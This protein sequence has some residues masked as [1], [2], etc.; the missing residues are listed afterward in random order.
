VHER[1]TNVWTEAGEVGWAL[2]V[3]L[4][5]TPRLNEFPFGEILTPDLH[6]PLRDEGC[7]LA[8]P[9]LKTAG[10]SMRSPHV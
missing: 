4:H 6:R 3:E 7:D 5:H 2:A 1:T 10:I 9:T 8:E